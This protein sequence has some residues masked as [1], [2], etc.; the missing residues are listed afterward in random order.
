MSILTSEH[1]PLDL[2]DDQS[3]L[4]AWLKNRNSTDP[5]D[6]RVLGLHR[7]PDG[8]A[9]GNFAG[10]VWLGEGDCRASLIVESK[11]AQMDYMAMYL[12]CAEDS[13]VADHLNNCF[14]FWPE[15]ELIE[16]RELPKLSELLIAAYLR[17]LNDLCSRHL[18]R[19]FNVA[20]ENLRGRVKCKILLHQQVKKNLVYGRQDRVFCA[21]QTINNDIGENRVLRAALE[22]STKFIN[23]RRIRHP[24]LHSW[25]RASRAALS[26]VTV[27]EVKKADFRNLR[28]RGAFAHYRRAIA[29]AKFVLLRL[30]ANPRAEISDIATPPFAINSAELFERYTEVIL[31]K[32]YPNLEAGYERNNTYG[33][34]DGFTSPVRPDFWTPQID[35]VGRILDAKYKKDTEPSRDDVY[36]MIAY[37]QHK[38]LLR[39]RLKTDANARVELALIYPD[40]NQ[41]ESWRVDKTDRSFCSPLSRWF[42]RCPA[43][44]ERGG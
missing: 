22:Q 17:E 9:P 32:K 1:K 41:S 36:Q 39:D 12:A 25:A 4:R 15:Q 6:N 3:E 40:F 35:G 28:T 33:D 16:A 42:V 24:I 8:L 38:N 13:I 34:R 18:R 11:F 14:D 43:S 10:A 27:T 31:R 30:G 44:D 7:K 2:S 21:Y 20:A 5:Q 29:L 37:S 19:H 26:D 23:A